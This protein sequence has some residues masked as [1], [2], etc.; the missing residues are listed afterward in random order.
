MLTREDSYELNNTSSSSHDDVIK[1]KHFP[2][3]WPFVRGIH[4]SPVNSPHKGQWRGALM[5]SMIC[6][7]IN[8][9]VNISEAGDLRCHRAHYDVIVMWIWFCSIPD[10][11]P[12]DPNSNIS[13]WL[14][15][16]ISYDYIW[17]QRWYMFNEHQKLRKDLERRY[18]NTLTLRWR[19]NERDSVSNHQPHD[20]LLNRLFTRRSKKTSKLRVTGLCAGNSPETGEFPAQR[21]SN[22]E[23][24]SIWWR[25][26]DLIHLPLVNMLA[27]IQKPNPRTQF[28]DYLYE[29]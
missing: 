7:W 22:A 26:H 3:Y 5:F 15:Y 14:W 17:L 9:W 23:N 8:G 29:H 28:M 11:Y 24:G 25:H 2:R 13:F 19:H 6:V 16:L 10:Q 4:R 27:V 21:A 18:G 1:W 20:C 12:W